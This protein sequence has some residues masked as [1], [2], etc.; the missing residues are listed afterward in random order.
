MRRKSVD[1]LLNAWVFEKPLISAL[2]LCA[3]VCYVIYGIPAAH[4]LSRCLQEL[5]QLCPVLGIG[6]LLGFLFLLFWFLLLFI[7][8]LRSSGLLYQTVP[9]AQI[10]FCA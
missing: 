8:V 2:K 3:E 10:L 1:S 6:G 7:V 5:E 4:R 9:G